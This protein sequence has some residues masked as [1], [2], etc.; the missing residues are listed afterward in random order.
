MLVITRGYFF[1]CHIGLKGIF[2]PVISKEM[3]KYFTNFNPPSTLPTSIFSSPIKWDIF[4]LKWDIFQLKWDFTNFYLFGDSVKKDVIF[5]VV[6]KGLP[7][8]ESRWKKPGKGTLSRET[9]GFKQ[10]G[11]GQN[12][13]T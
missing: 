6:E 13:G 2:S 7:Q 8:V 9:I 4:Q 10:M 11:M 1:C 3:V 12:P 5:T